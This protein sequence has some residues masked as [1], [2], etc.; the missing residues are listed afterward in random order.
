MLR[1]YATFMSGVFLVNILGDALAVGRISGGEALP[2][3]GYLFVFVLGTLVFW[4]LESLDKRLDSRDEEP[5][6]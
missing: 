6:D 4:G 1:R 5:Q 3:I 2:P